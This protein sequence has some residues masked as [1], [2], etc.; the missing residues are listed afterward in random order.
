MQKYLP[1]DDGNPQFHGKQIHGGMIS[2]LACVHAKQLPEKIKSP[3][4]F[5][6]VFIIIKIYLAFRVHQMCRHAVA[7]KEALS[8]HD[9]VCWWLV[10]CTGIHRPDC[11]R[12]TWFNFDSAVEFEQSFVVSA[13]ASQLPTADLSFLEMKGD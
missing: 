1:A 9:D 6:E 5:V 12:L 13:A 3:S 2:E 10:S 11:D 7:N 4:E 8:L